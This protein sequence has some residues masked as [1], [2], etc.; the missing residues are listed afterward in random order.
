M[1]RLLAAAILAIVGGGPLLAAGAEAHGADITTIDGARF[2]GS[3][4]VGPGREPVP[5]GFADTVQVPRD[6]P[7]IQGAVDRAEP[8]GWS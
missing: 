6:S 8:G 1:R 3:G 4:E 7:T 5:G 2:L